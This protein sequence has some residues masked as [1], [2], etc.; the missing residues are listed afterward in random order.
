MLED[1]SKQS[2]YIGIIQPKLEQ[3]Q[4]NQEL[5][6]VGTLTKVV[7]SKA[8]EGRRYQIIVRGQC[9]FVLDKEIA[10]PDRLYRN[11]Q[12]R[13][14]GFSNDGLPVD[15]SLDRDN[16]F[17]LLD[18]YLRAKKMNIRIKGLNKLRNHQVI[19]IACQ[20]LPLG[21]VEKQALLEEASIEARAEKLKAFMQ[22]ETAGRTHSRMPQSDFL[23]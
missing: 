21:R 10:M 12:V 13:Y 4:N 3:D 5:F 8:I 14:D 15:F 19:D 18:Q 9:R 1:L 22:M 23:N 20:V 2:P 17:V 6:S 11:A 7:E 16:F